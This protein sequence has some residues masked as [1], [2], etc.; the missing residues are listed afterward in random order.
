MCREV[1]HP[2]KDRRLGSIHRIVGRDS[3]IIGFPLCF[4]FPIPCHPISCKICSRESRPFHWVNSE[5]A[6]RRR[7]FIWPGVERPCVVVPQCLA[8]L[9]VSDQ[10][11]ERRRELT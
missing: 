6:E 11:L 5:N 4:P 2:L 7:L 3:R 1:V 10:A 9:M 8:T